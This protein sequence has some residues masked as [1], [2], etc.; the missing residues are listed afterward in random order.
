[1]EQII[2]TYRF[3]SRWR[4]VFIATAVTVLIYNIFYY[5]HPANRQWLSSGN[6]S[7]L[8]ML[9]FLLLEQ[10]LINCIT[11]FIIFFSTPYYARLTRLT[12]INDGWKDLL[13]YLLKFLPFFLLVYFVYA[14]FSLLASFIYNEFG[15]WT[16]GAFMK[17]YFF[18]NG[19]IYLSYLPPVTVLG[20]TC[21]LINYFQEKEASK[22]LAAG[23]IKKDDK[24]KFI[25]VKDEA[26]ELPV[27]LSKV[28][29][30]KKEERKYLVKTKEYNY[31]SRNTLN[32]LEEQLPPDDFIRIN[33]GAIVATTNI[34]NYSFW[35]N[36]KYIL[37]TKDGEE[38][39]MS[40]E[41]L[42]KIK[43]LLPA[44]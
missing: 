4:N 28:L 14:P 1:M 16:M 24:P 5:L 31:Y 9:K 19:N 13:V 25:Y 43:E 8:N 20:Y 42:K 44:L 23:S 3:F 12:A 38:F 18:I 27:E 10:F 40:R 22:K 11:V 35:E 39:I 26:G 21:L 15:H 2:F 34:R 33:R 17:S 30:I 36:E 6:F 37:R 41:R 7:W 29:W 32:E